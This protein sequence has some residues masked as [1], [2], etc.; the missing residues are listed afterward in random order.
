MRRDR[1]GVVV[2]VRELFEQRRLAER[3][4]AAVEVRAA[5]SSHGAALAAH[6]E[7][8]PAPGPL[9]PASLRAHR[10]A[11]VAL[12]D[13]AEVAEQRYDAAVRAELEAGRRLVT[14][15]TARR[16]VERLAERQRV[17]AALVARRLADRRMDDLALQSWRRRA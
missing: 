11:G 1:L 4:A 6:R 3:A 15:A 8:V 9:D 7:H 17:E 12:G 5:A 16:S 2:R 10:L 14:A 13:V